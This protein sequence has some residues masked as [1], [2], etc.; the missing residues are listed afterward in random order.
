MEVLL[1]FFTK[2][3]RGDIVGFLLVAFYDEGDSEDD[4]GCCRDKEAKDGKRRNEYC[5][6]RN[7]A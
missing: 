2:D 4:V 3:G 1:P 5:T 6:S 7:Q